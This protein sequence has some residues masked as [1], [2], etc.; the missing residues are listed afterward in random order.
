MPDSQGLSHPSQE[1]G[2]GGHRGSP[3]TGESGPSLGVGEGCHV[4]LW[5]GLARRDPWPG[6][7]VGSWRLTLLWGCWGRGWGPQGEDVVSWASGRLGE[8]WGRWLGQKGLGEHSRA[9][10]GPKKCKDIRNQSRCW[11]SSASYL[12][13]NLRFLP[14]SE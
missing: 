3:S 4:G 12:F 2:T 14:W 5:V 13:L 8:P 9:L 7:A 6:R 1:L 10:H 11:L